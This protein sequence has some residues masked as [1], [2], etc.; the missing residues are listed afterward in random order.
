MN[1]EVIHNPY[2]LPI[3]RSYKVTNALRAEK[4][5]QKYIDPKRPR[6]M[7]LRHTYD[8]MRNV[9]NLEGRS[10]LP[11]EMVEAFLRRNGFIKERIR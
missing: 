4:E 9:I 11:V 8:V 7:K 10:A 1:I 5:I 2:S 6:G 3:S